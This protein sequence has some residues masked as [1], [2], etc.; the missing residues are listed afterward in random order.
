MNENK[1]EFT[2][3]TI[4]Y[5]GVHGKAPAHNKKD[6]WTFQPPANYGRKPL[7]IYNVSY[8]TAKKELDKVAAHG[9]EFVLLP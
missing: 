8:S 7:I 2:V 9:G 3:N 5:E 1:L 6:N 4:Y